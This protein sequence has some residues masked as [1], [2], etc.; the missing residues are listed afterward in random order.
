MVS[1]LRWKRSASLRMDRSV[2]T[3][4]RNIPSCSVVPCF[5]FCEV[6]IFESASFQDTIYLKPFRDIPRLFLMRFGLPFKSS[7]I[8]AFPRRTDV[9]WSLLRISKENGTEHGWQGQVP[10]TLLTMLLSDDACGGQCD[11]FWR[12]TR[13]LLMRIRTGSN[14]NVVI[15]QLWWEKLRKDSL[16]TIDRSC[17]GVVDGRGDWSAEKMR[18][19]GKMRGNRCIL[20]LYGASYDARK[21]RMSEK[22]YQTVIA[23]LRSS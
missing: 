20:N 15:K 3:A 6:H 9:C 12:M 5:W 10:S 21:M 2:T 8:H 22:G 19:E 7:S 1:E 4:Y 13:A 18:C 23:C 14:N 17:N 11:V 16:I